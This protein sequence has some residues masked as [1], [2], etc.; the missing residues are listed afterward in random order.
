MTAD[1]GVIQGLETAVQTGVV[2]HELHIF[3]LVTDLHRRVGGVGLVIV[4]L[5]VLDEGVLL[6][7]GEVVGTVQG[8]AQTLQPGSVVGEVHRVVEVLAV[9]LG[10]TGQVGIQQDDRV[11]VL[12]HHGIVAGIVLGG[13][14]HPRL[15]GQDVV[16]DVPFLVEGTHAQV[17]RL[18][19]GGSVAHRQ[20]LGQV[21]GDVGVEVI[22]LVTEGVALEDGVI[23]GIT[24][25]EV[26]VDRFGTAG[27]G[28]IVLL[29]YGEFLVTLVVPVG[30]D[31]V[32]GI[33][34]AVRPGGIAV[35]VCGDLGVG[36][37]VVHLGDVG[38]GVVPL[39]EGDPVFDLSRD[40][41]RGE[42]HGGGEVHGRLLH[43]ALLRGDEDD[44]VLGTETVDGRGSVLQHGNALDVV[45]IE[46][47]EDGDII[48]G[49]ELAGV[50][51]PGTSILARTGDAADD[52]VD[53]DHRV[54]VTAD[55]EVGIELTG[56]TAVLGDLEAGNLALEGVDAISGTGGGDVLGTDLGDGSGQ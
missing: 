31:G 11:H 8:Q 26:V 39:H 3:G 24:D 53:D 45:R 50:V 51:A 23:V 42:V 14:A 34:V 32:M 29:V 44:A 27:E 36:E 9:G 52:A 35:L 10:V 55:G 13:N 48:V 6:I 25:T 47:L 43:L 17:V 18:T 22:T 40:V 19:D 56:L 38:H 33:S 37:T 54:A 49:L 41:R 5:E 46:F 15:C 2:V 30:I 20:V 28:G 4:Q 16:E 21:D 1:P 7:V 12:V